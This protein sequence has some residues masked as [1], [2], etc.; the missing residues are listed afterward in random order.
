MAVFVILFIYLALVAVIVQRIPSVRKRR[1]SQTVLSGF[2]LWI[3]LALRSPLCGID[4][5]QNGYG[6]IP[7]F[8]EIA[9]M[10]FRDFVRMIVSGDAFV[11]FELGWQFLC[12][13]ISF[14]S[15]SP[16]FFLAVI[17]GIGVLL[18]SNVIYR[19]SENIFLSFVVYMCFDLYLFSFSGL[20]Q[21]TALVV[22]F[23]AFRYIVEQKPVRFVL[24]V[25]AAVTMHAS[26]VVFFVMYPLSKVRL[27]MP[28]GIGMF[29]GLVV[30]IPF[31]SQIVSFLVGMIFGSRFLEYENEGGSVTMFVVYSLIFFLTYLC[32]NRDNLNI[33]RW[34]ILMAVAS[35]SLGF[36]STGAMTRIGYYFS[37]FFTLVFPLIIL[38]FKGVKFRLFITMVAAILFF[39]FFYLTSSGGYLNVVPYHFFWEA[40]QTI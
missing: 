18:V 25:L 19:Y 27:N 14:F 40:N 29:G 8:S 32:R 10:P 20:R 11:G 2:G 16:Q 1:L 26:A 15:S 17:A 28:M 38:S 4:L 21:A 6:Y 24:T 9:E 39:L 23:Y 3:V 33:Y 37:I 12:K 35:Q 7:V 36:I 22:T 13:F 31:L 34:A 30:L 5:Y